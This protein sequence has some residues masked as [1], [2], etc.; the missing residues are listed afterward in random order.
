MSS[1]TSNLMEMTVR[2]FNLEL[3]STFQTIVQDLIVRICRTEAKIEDYH[4]T[5]VEKLDHIEH[6]ITQK[7]E[8]MEQMAVLATSV[9]DKLPSISKHLRKM[10]KMVPSMNETL[11]GITQELKKKDQ[12][13]LPR[14]LDG[15]LDNILRE[16]NNMEEMV[17]NTSVDD[18]LAGIMQKMDQMWWDQ[19]ALATSVNDEL[20]GITQDLE[21]MKEMVWH[22]PH[23]LEPDEAIPFFKRHE[24]SVFPYDAFVDK[25]GSFLN[26]LSTVEKNG[27]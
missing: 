17:L 20:A 16:L 1:E 19:T 24:Q 26:G 2:D 21:E 6:D 9:S 4:K 25:F 15:R 23:V 10:E 18:E 8:K 3:S 11:D 22:I 27:A 14:S 5:V 7:L 13:V 12:M